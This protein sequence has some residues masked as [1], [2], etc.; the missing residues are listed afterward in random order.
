MTVTI[1]D[2]GALQP[3][4]YELKY[5]GANYNLLRLS[6][7]KMVSSSASPPSTADGMQITFSGAPAARR[8]VSDPADP[9][10]REGF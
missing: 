4:D 8:P 9:R 5:D 2:L 3:S 1:A 6:D 10:W 7:N